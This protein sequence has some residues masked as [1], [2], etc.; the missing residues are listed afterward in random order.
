MSTE[1]NAEK[2]HFPQGHEY[3]AL[4]TYTCPSG[5]RRCRG[6]RKEKP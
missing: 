1:A 2:T 4:N 5:K 6:G 3:T